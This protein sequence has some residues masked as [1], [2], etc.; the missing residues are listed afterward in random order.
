MIEAALAGDV[1]DGAGAA[2]FFV[3]DAEDQSLDA[4]EGEGAGAHGA[5]FFGDVEG[6]AGEAPVAEGV[7]GLGDGE[8]FGV[9][10]G[11]FEEFDLVVGAG[12]DLP[13]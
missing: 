7:G 13:P 2:G 10:G 4:G 11:V 6:A 3:A 9:G 8:H 1:E 5:G 12:D